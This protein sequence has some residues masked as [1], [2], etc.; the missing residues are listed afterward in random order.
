MNENL[1]EKASLLAPVIRMLA[2]EGQSIVSVSCDET[3]AGT[4]DSIFV[5]AAAD[6]SVSDETIKSAINGK[7]PTVVAV[8]GVG[9]FACGETKQQAD[10]ILAAAKAALISVG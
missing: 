8:Q 4:P 6:G 1:K 5:A 2:R 9:I 7:S 3:V 10:A